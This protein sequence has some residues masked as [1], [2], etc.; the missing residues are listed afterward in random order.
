MLSKAKTINFH[1]QDQEKTLGT[2]F[3]SLVFF[4]KMH[5]VHNAKGNNE[6]DQLV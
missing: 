6:H 1:K 2:R 3:K 4:K 5:N